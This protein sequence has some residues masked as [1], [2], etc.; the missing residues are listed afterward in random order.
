MLSRRLAPV[1]VL[2]AGAA[3]AAA[4]LHAEDDAGP[5]VDGEAYERYTD[6]RA[7]FV[8]ALERVG[9]GTAAGA[10]DSE[11]LRA[12]P[13][14]RY[15]RAARIEHALES[16]SGA[17][18]PAD[19]RAQSFLER[20]AGEPV[21]RTLRRA[22]LS[23]LVRREQWRRFLDE[24][25]EGTGDTTLRCQRVQ[26]RI[27]LGEG[28]EAAGE[29][30]ELWLTGRQLP[31]DCEPVF[32]WL[33]AEGHLTDALVEQRV[34]LLLENGHAAFARVIADRLPP[35]RAAPLLRWADLL[36]RPRVSL[37]RLLDAPATPLPDGALLDGWR[38]LT[39]NQPAAA[40]E[41]YAEIVDAFGL[42]ADA[43]SRFTLALALGL[44]WD[45]RPE[46]LEM[47]A[48]VR[49][50]DLDDYA[51]GWL[52][53]AALWARDWSRARQ[54]MDAMTAATREETRWRYWDAR[55][56]EQLGERRRARELYRSIL[57]TDNYYSAMAAARLDEPVE[58]HQ[59]RLDRD[60][61]VV[62]ELASRPAFVR[63]R[64][65]LYAQ[66]PRSAA[67]E[68]R[69]GS[70]AL[71]RTVRSQTIHLAAA[72]RWYDMAIATATA[73]GVFF[74][75]ELLYPRPYDEPVRAAASLTGL[76]EALIYAVIRQE[77]LYRRDAA[78]PAGAVGLAQ[79][80]PDT[81]RRAARRWDQPV[82]GYSELF[83]PEVNVTLGAA[84]L[85]S[86]IDDFSAQ[87]PVALAA[88]NAGPNAARRWLPSEPLDPDVWIENI[89]YN[90]T[91]SYV[92]RVLWHSLVFAW[93]ES[94]R[95]RD[96]GS[97]LEPVEAA[98]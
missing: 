86:L 50:G 60:R 37:D 18:T 72:W 32:Q 7:R 45:R 34:A 2:I 3:L 71:E 4:A 23:S 94:G 82:P 48:R 15:L 84:E 54:A 28:G 19:A 95:A 93:L 97:W 81:A 68:W 40:L 91:R 98:D 65:L 85:R 90:E 30:I 46:A 78:S 16:A 52:V 44:A 21:A 29:G 6:E 20:H 89:P 63:A 5:Y 57:P 47:F 77:S 92:Q 83:E 56:A 31:L 27:A 22:W 38:R 55:I 58:P 88:Y 62:R 25:S 67:A 14:Y 79:L 59:R 53:R 39:R 75:Y 24:A 49:P 69:H 9:E 70:D 42:D 10:E 17:D 80:H 8:E 33:R 51:L 13:L 41:R 36:E 74:D 64:E 73:R 66:R 12:Y 35:E 87:L 96:T 1:R 26:A 76:E 61:A 11:A 43:E